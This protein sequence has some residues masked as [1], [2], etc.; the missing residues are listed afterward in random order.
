MQ[1]FVKPRKVTKKREVKAAKTMEEYASNLAR[2]GGIVDPLGIGSSKILRLGESNQ[3]F[4]DQNS[5]EYI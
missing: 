2:H 5:L 1:A 3:R 4:Y